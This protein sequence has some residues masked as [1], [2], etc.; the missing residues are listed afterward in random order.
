MVLQST[1]DLELH[2]RVKNMFISY[3]ISLIILLIKYFASSLMGSNPNLKLPE[4]KQEKV[5]QDEDKSKRKWRV[6]ANDVENIPLDLSVFL[7]AFLLTCFAILSKE[8][9][10][11]ALGLTILICLYTFGR[12]L[13]M[14]FY[15]AALQPW[16]SI[17]FL[18]G[19]I[20]TLCALG[21]MVSSAFK[22]DSARFIK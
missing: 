12:I 14:I 18:I 10:S 11:E 13:F 7:F 19:K 3:S 21:I 8:G 2:T 1:N 5:D 17:A 4:D 6:T 16:R 22:I 15:L 20:S 9:G